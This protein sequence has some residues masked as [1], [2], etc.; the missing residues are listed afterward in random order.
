MSVVPSPRPAAAR[1]LATWPLILASACAA[2]ACLAAIA[3]VFAAP[4]FRDVLSDFGT[5]LPLLSRITLHSPWLAGGAGL[6]LALAA[7]VLLAV[8]LAWPQL[9]WTGRVLWPLLAC[10]LLVNLGLLASLYLPILSLS[11]V[12]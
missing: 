10:A 2:L 1:P 5:E 6:L 12:V 8:R 3:Y 11:Q 7:S 9:R 4:Q